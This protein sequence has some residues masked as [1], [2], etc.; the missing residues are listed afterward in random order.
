[1][2]SQIWMTF[3]WEKVWAYGV[4]DA[5]INRTTLRR[6]SKIDAPPVART[7]RSLVG[8]SA[9]A[10]LLVRLPSS[11]SRPNNIINLTHGQC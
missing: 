4:Q 1:M 10:I 11:K 5:V 7:N 3:R 2:T 6:C 9:S 8:P